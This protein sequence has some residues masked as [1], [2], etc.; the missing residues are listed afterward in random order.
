MDF[1]GLMEPFQEGHNKEDYKRRLGMQYA[2]VTNSRKIWAFMDEIMEYSI[3]R[4]E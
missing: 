2:V 4:D 3:I 1:I